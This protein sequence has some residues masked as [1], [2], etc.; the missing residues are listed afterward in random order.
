MDASAKARIAAN[1]AE[2]LRRRAKRRRDEC[3]VC[4][5]DAV[6]SLLTFGVRVCPGHQSSEFELVP[7]TE[8]IE[9]Y[10]LPKSTMKT[11]TFVEKTNPR[12][13]ATPMRLYLRRDLAAA[14]TER[15]GSAAALE[16]ERQRR[17]DAKFETGAK[18]ARKF[19][20]PRG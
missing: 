9:K 11:L 2:A 20:T 10:L 16:S 4:G 6:S 17:S 5:A 14:A 19:F 1:K 8:A 7:S 18:K 13:F 3:A 12:G 15:W